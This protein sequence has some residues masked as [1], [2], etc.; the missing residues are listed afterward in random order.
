MANLSP[1]G[2]AGR[3][4]DRHEVTDAHGARLPVSVSWDP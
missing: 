2:M 1:P 4:S 3:T